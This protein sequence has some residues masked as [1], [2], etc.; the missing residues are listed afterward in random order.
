MLGE[1]APFDEI[2][3]ATL[4]TTVAKLGLA[5]DED[6]VFAELKRLP[7]APDAREALE[8]AGRA[9]VLTNGGREGGEHLLE[10]AS[11]SR[12]VERVFGVDEVQAFK[13]DPRPYRHVVDQIGESTLIATH[14]WDCMGARNAGMQAVWVQSDEQAWPFPNTMPPTKAETLVEA[15][16]AATRR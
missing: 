7:A 5:V 1:F 9:F 16:E 3:R 14:A 2:A 13:P 15:V 12:L 4:S 8:Q 11:L 10:R 6:E